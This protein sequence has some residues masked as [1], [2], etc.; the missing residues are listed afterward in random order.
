M[1]NV[2]YIHGRELPS[3]KQGLQVK[4]WYRTNMAKQLSSLHRTPSGTKERKSN[5]QKIKSYK[6]VIL[7]ADL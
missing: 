2:L 4:N 5:S 6:L 1:Q 3:A 7:I